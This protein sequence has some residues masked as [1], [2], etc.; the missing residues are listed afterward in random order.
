MGKRKKTM[1]VGEQEN[2]TDNDL[3]TVKERTVDVQVHEN[4]PKRVC[5]SLLLLSISIRGLHDP[6]FNSNSA[7]PKQGKFSI[8]S[9]SKT[10]ITS[11]RLI[12]TS[13]K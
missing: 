5:S 9:V 12:Q 11:T 10:K 8:K 2:E 13:Q 3:T 7:L 6:G 4:K 1:R